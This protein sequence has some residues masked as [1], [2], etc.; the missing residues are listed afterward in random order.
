MRRVGLAR[1]KE[2]KEGYARL[3]FTHDDTAIDPAVSDELDGRVIDGGIVV[4][5]GGWEGD[6]MSVGWMWGC[7]VEVEDGG[8]FA[9]ACRGK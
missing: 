1:E 7:T 2:D 9:S 4:G 6:Q 8:E 5:V 3:A